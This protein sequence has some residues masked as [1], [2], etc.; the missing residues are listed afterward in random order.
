MNPIRHP[1]RRRRTPTGKLG[2]H[3]KG[4]MGTNRIR[5]LRVAGVAVALLAVIGSATAAQAAKPGNSLNAK[6]CQKGGWQNLVTSTGASFADEQQCTSY[7]AGGGVL[8]P[9]PPPDPCA[10]N[11]YLDLYRQDGT[12]FATAADCTAYSAQRVRL[13][14]TQQYT[15][16]DHDFRLLLYVTVAGAGLKPGTSPTTYARYDGAGGAFT[17][18]FEGGAILADG[19]VDESAGAHECA[20]FGS[21]LIDL[22]TTATTASGSPVTSRKILPTLCPTAGA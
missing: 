6:A 2:N 8:A 17:F 18:H 11:G 9:K 3:K 5:G 13:A 16:V 19:T 20:A 14:L 10:T 21:Q 4:F 15:Y 12:A 1:R 22:Q 7:A